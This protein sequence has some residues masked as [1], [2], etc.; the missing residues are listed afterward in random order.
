MKKQ[1]K[2]P[3]PYVKWF[4]RGAQRGVFD[5][6]SNW[7]FTLLALKISVF[8]GFPKSWHQNNHLLIVYQQKIFKKENYPKLPNFGQFP[9]PKIK[10]NVFLGIFD[11][12]I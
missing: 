8:N 9:F 1:K 5:P 6:Y 11:P 10:I 2:I 3:S 7:N 4:P 12:F